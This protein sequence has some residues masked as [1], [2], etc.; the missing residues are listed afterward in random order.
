MAF[1][2]QYL[3]DGSEVAEAPWASDMPPTRQFARDG[4][5]F[6]KADTAIIRDEVG[7]HLPVITEKLH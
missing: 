7:K 2:I 4:I 3:K 6:R 5:K 1:T